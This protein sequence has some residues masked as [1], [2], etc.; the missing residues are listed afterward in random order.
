V[1]DEPEPIPLA[2]Q[3]VVAPMTAV[4]GHILQ[5]CF[6]DAAWFVLGE[7]PGDAEAALAL[8]RSGSEERT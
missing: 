7:D 8:F 1:Y 4:V 2:P 3:T 5:P 6:H